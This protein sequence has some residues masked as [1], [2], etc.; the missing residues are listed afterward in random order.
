MSLE[1]LESG[2]SP[3]ISL[4]LGEYEEDEMRRRNGMGLVV[5]CCRMETSTREI[6]RMAKE[7]VMENIHSSRVK[8]GNL[9]LFI[10]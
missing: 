8:Q 1:S 10:C 6:I 3:E 2:Q 7:M 5:L 4:F 9:L